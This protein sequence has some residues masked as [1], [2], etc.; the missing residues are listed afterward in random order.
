MN[1]FCT[2]PSLTSIE[3]RQLRLPNPMAD[4]STSMPM[5]ALNSPL[6]SGNRTMLADS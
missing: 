2:T 1:I 3:Y 4:L 5:P 6:P